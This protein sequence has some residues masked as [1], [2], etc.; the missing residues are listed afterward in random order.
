MPEAPEQSDAT[1][2]PSENAKREDPAAARA[3]GAPARGDSDRRRQP[4]PMFS[5]FLLV[6]RRRAGRRDGE[7]DRIYVDHPGAWVIAAFL[8]VTLLS[9][10]DAY[11]TLHELALGVGVTEENPVMRAALSLGNGGFVFVKTIVT[12]VGVGFLGLHKNWPLGR[13][14]LWVAVAGYAALTAYH[15][16]GVLFLLPSVSP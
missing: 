12:V 7:R 2:A 15:L 10:A 6:G 1:L 4:T 13:A 9:V 8:A 16:W 11:F 5:R 14:C 3:T